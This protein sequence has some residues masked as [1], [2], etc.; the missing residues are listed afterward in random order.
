VPILFLFH[1]ILPSL[2]AAIATWFGLSL[3]RSLL[4]MSVEA[5]TGVL[6][7]PLHPVQMGAALMLGY[8]VPGEFRHSSQARWAWLLPGMYLACR[9]VFW[10]RE[11]DSGSV[12]VDEPTSVYQAWAYFFGSCVKGTEW[13]PVRCI[14]QTYATLPLQASV[15]YSVGALL[16]QFGV[17]R[18]QRV[19]EGASGASAPPAVSEEGNSHSSQNHG[20]SSP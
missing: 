15:A 6:L 8:I 12:L 13:N 10:S 1:T 16:D 19:A 4:P 7:H 2:G 14:D 18:F 20:D 9:I 5:M 17:F 11:G 3:L